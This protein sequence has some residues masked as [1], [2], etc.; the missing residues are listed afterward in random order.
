MTAY[1]D[2]SV[3]GPHYWFFLN[4][5]ALNYPHYPNTITKKKYYD[6]F[7][8]LPLFIP[9]EKVANNFSNLLQEYP[10]VP[11][12]DNRESLVRWIHFIHNKVNEQLEKPKIPLSQF[13]VKY[14]EAYKPKDIKAR[15][16]LKMKKRAVYFAVLAFV[17]GMIYW[18]YKK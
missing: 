16:Y 1:L 11:Y 12:L 7:Q 15:E 13:Y 18:F 6:L 10:I 5:V 4:T 8:N 2:P 14:Y 3:W 9:V 17:I